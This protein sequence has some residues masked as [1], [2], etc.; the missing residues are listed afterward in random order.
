MAGPLLTR[1][2][3][4]VIQIA[5]LLGWKADWLVQVGVGNYHHEFD[6]L[7]HNWPDLRVIG[8]EAHPTIFKGVKDD[9]P[10]ELYNCAVSD[11][12]EESVTLYFNMKHKDGSSVFEHQT[13]N[14]R[15]RYKTV[16]VYEGDM[17][18]GDAQRGR[19]CLLGQ[20]QPIGGLSLLAYPVDAAG[21]YLAILLHRHV[22]VR[23]DGEQE[24]ALRFGVQVEEQQGVGLVRRGALAVGA[25]DQDGDGICPAIGAQ[26]R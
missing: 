21:A 11:V 7:L 3:R 22:Q 5:G 18:Y 9:Y 24:R 17:A 20:R 23:W 10:G 8:F 15:G 12:V 16:E 25:Q 26:A 4:A 1:S 19:D 2:G 14:P 6:V 13:K